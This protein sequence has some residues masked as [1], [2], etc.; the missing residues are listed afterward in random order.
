MRQPQS[1][2]LSLI[3]V[4]CHPQPQVQQV[5][6]LR[7]WP[8]C[9]S[10]KYHRGSWQ[11]ICMPWGEGWHLPSQQERLRCQHAVGMGGVM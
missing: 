9:A 10:V 7:C 3:W 1:Y 5:R 2:H 8:I 11:A 4:T 6:V